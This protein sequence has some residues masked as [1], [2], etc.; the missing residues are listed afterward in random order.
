MQATALRRWVAGI[1]QATCRPNP[2]GCS[3]IPV[4]ERDDELITT[5]DNNSTHLLVDLKS[6]IEKKKPS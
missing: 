1:A 2:N 4:L 3:S 5:T 6:S